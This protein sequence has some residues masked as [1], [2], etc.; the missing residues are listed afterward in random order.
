MGGCVVI[1][2]GPMIMV[3]PGLSP[4]DFLT[5][6]RAPGRLSLNIDSSNLINKIFTRRSGNIPITRNR[7][8]YPIRKTMWREGKYIITTLSNDQNVPKCGFGQCIARARMRGSLE[9]C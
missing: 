2:P 5:P 1:G 6:T 7:E 9:I 8:K 3:M 4:H